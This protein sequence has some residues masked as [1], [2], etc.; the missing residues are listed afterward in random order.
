MSAKT[1]LQQFVVQGRGEDALH[2]SQA[3]GAF[4][5][6]FYRDWSTDQQQ[7]TIQQQQH[8]HL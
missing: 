1:P 2:A 6:F 5:L 3:F 4:L 8:E 7:K